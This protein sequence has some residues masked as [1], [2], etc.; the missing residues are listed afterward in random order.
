MAAVRRLT[1]LNVG[2]LNSPIKS[3]HLSINV[4]VKTLKHNFSFLLSFK[5]R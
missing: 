2:F 3:F 4:L 5:G 1:E